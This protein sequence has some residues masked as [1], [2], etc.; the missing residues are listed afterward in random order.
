MGKIPQIVLLLLIV[1]LATHEIEAKRSRYRC[2]KCKP[3][4]LYREVFAYITHRGK[5]PDR[6]KLNLR[7]FQQSKCEEEGNYPHPLGNCRKYLRCHKHGARP[8]LL[9]C[10]P[11]KTF[12]PFSREC[13]DELEARDCKACNKPIGYKIPHERGGRKFYMCQDGVAYE[14]ECIG[15][16]KFNRHTR[17]C[18]NAKPAVDPQDVDETYV[19][20]SVYIHNKHG[21]KRRLFTGMQFNHRPD[22]EEKKTYR[23]A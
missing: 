21:K 4:G 15:D 14:F 10:R 9:E 12:D 3:K 11:G 6:I 5:N 16:R 22:S 8:K 1:T 18:G 13:L 23:E 19:P 20:G 17:S 2:A 7:F